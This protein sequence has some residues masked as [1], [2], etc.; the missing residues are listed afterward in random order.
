M[1]HV[2][3]MRVSFTANGEE[4]DNP[5]CE[6]DSCEDAYAEGMMHGIQMSAV[7][8]GLEAFDG[9]GKAQ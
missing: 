1:R 4:D 7:K 6:V 2:Y 5:D 8:Q 9:T 3:R